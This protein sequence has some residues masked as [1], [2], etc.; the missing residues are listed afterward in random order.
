MTDL[1]VDSG[2]GERETKDMVLRRL[3][4]LKNCEPIVY[5]ANGSIWDQACCNKHCDHENAA[6]TIKDVMIANFHKIRRLS[7]QNITFWL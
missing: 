6:S 7:S 1:L 2:E 4:H 5:T 3:M